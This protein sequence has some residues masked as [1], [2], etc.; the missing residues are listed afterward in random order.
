MEAISV[1]DVVELSVDSEPPTVLE[2][3]T[4]AANEV[5]ADRDETRT[6]ITQ[7]YVLFSEAVN[8]PEGHSDPDDVTNPAN[9]ILVSDGGDG[10]FD[11]L[12][13]EGGVSPLDKQ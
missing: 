4:I 12:S 11:T 1:T 5:L 10:V 9:Y 13:C 7:L 2:I 3:R 8:D 6:A